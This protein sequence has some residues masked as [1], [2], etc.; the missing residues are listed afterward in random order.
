[1]NPAKLDPTPNWQTISF[2]WEVGP[3]AVV[4][5]LSTVCSHLELVVYVTPIRLYTRFSSDISCLPALWYEV[6]RSIIFRS[7]NIFFSGFPT[8]WLLYC[9]A[10]SVRITSDPVR[11]SRVTMFSTPTIM[12]TSYSGRCGLGCHICHPYPHCSAHVFAHPCCVLSSRSLVLQD[13]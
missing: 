13:C 12:K 1:M 2:D 3:A 6:R 5:Q 7:H 11:W 9:I 4:Q 10:K 8:S